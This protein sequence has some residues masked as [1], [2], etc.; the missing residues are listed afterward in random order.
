M[1][2]TAEHNTIIKVDIHHN[3]GIARSADSKVTSKRLDT[4]HSTKVIILRG[5]VL[6]LRVLDSDL[7]LCSSFPVPLSCLLAYWPKSNIAQYLPSAIPK[8]IAVLF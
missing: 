8:I 3:T 2:L 4:I 1:V 7:V 6:V 5:G